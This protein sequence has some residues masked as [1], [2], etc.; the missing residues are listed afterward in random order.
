MTICDQCPCFVDIEPWCQLG[1]FPIDDADTHYHPLR[2]AI[3]PMKQIELMDGR[4]I[5]PE[6]QDG[7]V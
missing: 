2:N 1:D 4:I 3:C 7:E 5:K 6:V